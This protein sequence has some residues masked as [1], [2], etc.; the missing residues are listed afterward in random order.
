[1]LAVSQVQHITPLSGSNN[2]L[3]A[4]SRFGEAPVT[5]LGEARLSLQFLKEC[6]CAPF[7]RTLGRSFDCEGS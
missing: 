1:M 2:M 4:Q 6:L 7:A 5:D 3:D